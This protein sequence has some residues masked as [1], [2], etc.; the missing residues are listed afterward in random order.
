MHARAC[1]STKPRTRARA[2]CE[3]VAQTRKRSGLP[4]WRCR[5]RRRRLLGCGC[6]FA[7]TAVMGTDHSG[8]HVATRPFRYGMAKLLPLLPPSSS[9]FVEPDPD[10]P[11]TQRAQTTEAAGAGVFIFRVAQFATCISRSRMNTVKRVRCV[12]AWRNRAHDT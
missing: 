4:L 1:V 2:Q 8:K 6:D 11:C 9:S 3:H 7:Y 10:D 12:C 5:R